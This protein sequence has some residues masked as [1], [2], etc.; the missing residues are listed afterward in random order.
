MLVVALTG[1]IGSGKTT[2]SQLFEAL[3]A[4]IVDTDIIARQ[5]VAPGEST[6][7]EIA[8]QFGETILNPDG[9][10]N[11]AQ[12]RQ[13]IFQNPDKKRL[14]ESILHPLIRKEM[15]R[16]IAALT[17]P[18]CIVVIPL[19]IESGQMEFAD[20][21]LVVDA[22]EAA[23]LARVSQR[24]NQTENEIA[25]IVASQASRDARLAVANDVIHN[26][27]TLDELK[28]QVATLHQKYLTIANSD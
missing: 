28:Q 22:T 10:L 24:D 12:L 23:Q 15:I 4:P 20:R 3:G 26:N 2:V 21:I 13:T 9:T 27:S 5:L 19:L 16:Q 17:S 1:G 6:L 11:R 18:Y 25:A 14:L 7:S 8:R